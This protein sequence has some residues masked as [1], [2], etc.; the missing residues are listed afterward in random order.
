MVWSWGG[1]GS[2]SGSEESSEGSDEGFHDD[3]VL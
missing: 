3:S 2:S 1:W